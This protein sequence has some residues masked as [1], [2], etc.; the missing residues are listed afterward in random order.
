MQH[1]PVIMQTP[2]AMH[3]DPV[4]TQSDLMATHHGQAATQR[5]LMATHHGR[6]ATQR[7][8]MATHHDPVATQ[9]DLMATYDPMTKQAHIATYPTIRHSTVHSCVVCHTHTMHT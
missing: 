4:D 5:D 6:E 2:M 3:H 1:N 9:R 7:D 8:L